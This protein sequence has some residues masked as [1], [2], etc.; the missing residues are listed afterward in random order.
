MKRIRAELSHLCILA[1]VCHQAI[2]IAGGAEV[3]LG[4]RRPP[5]S[6]SNLLVLF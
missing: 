1:A 3:R 4:I 2:D 6:I 5:L